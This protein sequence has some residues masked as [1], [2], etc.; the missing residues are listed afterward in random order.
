RRQDKLGHGVCRKLDVERPSQRGDM[1]NVLPNPMIAVRS[2][3]FVELR[4]L[5][6]LDR[7]LDFGAAKSKHGGSSG[8]DDGYLYLGRSGLEGIKVVRG[9]S[10]LPPCCILH[11]CGVLSTAE[12]RNRRCCALMWGSQ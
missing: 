5:H 1:I 9:L 11:Q 6:G 7:R 2:H 8:C 3:G 12:Y 4:P 10:L